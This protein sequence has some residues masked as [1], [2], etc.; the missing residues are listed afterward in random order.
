MRAPPTDD[1]PPP[2]PPAPARRVG[3]PTNEL[4]RQRFTRNLNRLL[5]QRPEL[6]REPAARAA[7]LARVC[8]VTPAAARKWLT[9]GGWPTLEKLFDLAQR[10]NF[11]AQDLLSDGPAQVIDISRLVDAQALR[12]AALLELTPVPEFPDSANALALAI[13]PALLGGVDASARYACMVMPDDSMAAQCRAGD[14]VV[15]RVEADWSGDGLYLLQASAVA[16]LVLRHVTRTD[17]GFRIVTRG[18]T[19][20]AHETPRLARDEAEALG[21]LPLLRG[22][23]VAVLQ[24]LEPAAR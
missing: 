4:F 12:L 23:A 6:P 16:P 21:G 8:G 11:A 1:V 13:D 18:A 5:D 22:R 20:A 15:F 7:E 10:Y 14:R 19:P 24:R 9:G 2:S 3:R 17:S